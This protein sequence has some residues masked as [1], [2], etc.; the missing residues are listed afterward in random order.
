MGPGKYC[1]VIAAETCQ[2]WDE[3][4]ETLH[5]FDDGNIIYARTS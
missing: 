4:F 5:K 2:I 1:W 3:N